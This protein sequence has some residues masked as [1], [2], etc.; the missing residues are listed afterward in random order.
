MRYI[1][2]TALLITVTY[3][4]PASAGEYGCGPAV[5]NWKNGSQTTWTYDSNSGALVRA[6]AGEAPT[7]PPVEV[8][9]EKDRRGDDST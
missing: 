3:D 4:S 6:E 5:Q 8:K 9:C 1:N 7:P 2:A